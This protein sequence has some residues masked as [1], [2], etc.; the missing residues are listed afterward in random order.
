[1]RT[2]VLHEVEAPVF[3][4]GVLAKGKWSLRQVLRVVW[5]SR[6][7]RVLIHI[8]LTW[9]LFLP[10]QDLDLTIASLPGLSI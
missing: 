7:L 10:S 5:V 8:F 9:V 2:H 6:F 3:S 1:M 4:S